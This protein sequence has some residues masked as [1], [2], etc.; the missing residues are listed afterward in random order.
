M[1]ASASFGLWPSP[2][3]PKMLSQ[4]LRLSDCAWDSDGLTLVWH[5][6]R[7]DRGVL[8]A[9][10]LDGDAPRDLT[11]ELSVRARVGYGGGDFCVGSGKVVF[12]SG[13]RLYAQSLSSGEGN[14]SGGGKAR[15][16][17]PAFGQ[18][19]A[20][21][22]SPDGK[23]VLFVHSVDR[24]DCL[25]VVDIDGKFW[26]Q[27]VAT[28]RDF[29]M[30][31][32]WSS[33]GKR[34]AFVAWDHPNMPWVSS[35]VYLAEVRVAA[36]ALPV[37]KNIRPISPDGECAAFQPEFSPSGSHLAW[38]CDE[39]ESD[40]PLWDGAGN[41]EGWHNIYLT[42]FSDRPAHRISNEKSAQLGAP[43]W[44]QGQRTLGWSHDGKSI[45]C[46]RNE[47]GFSSFWSFPINGKKPAQVLGLGEYSDLLQP[48]LHPK[49]PLVALLASGGKQTARLLLQELKGECA[50]TIVKRTTSETIPA[51]LLSAPQ[52][53]HWRGP[54]GEQIHALLYLPRFDGLV[55]G[56][57][58][59]ANAPKPPAIVR[60]HG[61]PTAQSRAAYSAEA[62]YYAT[63][64]YV[65]LDL[66]YRG[67]TGYGRAYMNALRGNWGIA[68]VEDAVGAARFLSDEGHADPAKLVILGGS[69]GGFTVL[70][71][72]VDHPGVY[73][74]GVCLYGVANQFTLVSDTHKFEEKYSDWLLGTLPEAAA[75]YRQRSPVFHAEKIADPL[76]VFQG[77]QD[78][79]VPK[80]QSDEIVATL[81]KRHVPHEYHI[82]EGEGH[83]WRKNETIE[84]YY[85]LTEK[86]LK[87]HVLFA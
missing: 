23:W 76:I 37:F 65:Y 8:V 17:T 55:A 75:I 21:V 16:I 73:K 63:R 69:A 25:A 62:Q 79:V 5:E 22:I 68:D 60:V 57:K 3:S 40:L 28:G 30:Q 46:V 11:D 84:K 36:G 6:G 71:T 59:G 70:Q 33:D 35:R 85:Q 31:A 58:A 81:K 45:F 10:R 52:A 72:L 50:T 24:Q 54:S 47:R 7:G 80:N 74:A 27:R 14:E 42:D 61:G 12:A 48:A 43:A 87:T 1:P 56:R 4:S 20:P 53:V 32:R 34:V 41:R 66:N 64:G 51:E 2:I 19:A 49:K 26:P 13:G 86:F 15:A 18:A 82:F 9:S 77:D 38:L 39:S 78:E 29:Y 83:G 44:T 67:S